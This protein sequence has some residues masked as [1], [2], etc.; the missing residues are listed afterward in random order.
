M[1]PTRLC[2]AVLCAMLPLS[3]GHAAAMDRSGQSVAALFQKGNYAEIGYSWLS[4][5]V[6]GTDTS[7]NAVPEMAKD[8]EFITGAIKVDAAPGTAL[9]FLYDQPYGADG[10]YTGNN[11]FVSATGNPF[12]TTGATLAEVKSHSYSLLVNQALNS[13][14]SVH[15]GL[16]YQTVEGDVQLRGPA[17]SVFNGYNLG[18]DSA[19]GLGW[20]LGGAFEKPDIALRAALTYRSEITTHHDTVE[21]NNFAQNANVAAIGAGVAGGTAAIPAT[22]TAL[23][24][25]LVTAQ[26]A[27]NTAAITQLTGKINQLGR[28]YALSQISPQHGSSTNVTTPQSINLDFQTGVMPG[29]LAFANVRWVDWSGFTI[30]PQLYSG[31]AQTPIVGYSKDQWSAQ[32]GLGHKF[33][34]LLSASVA[35][36]WDSGAGN[37]VT[38][39]GPTEGYTGVGV[40]VK[41][42]PTPALDV[43]LGARYLWLGDAEAQLPNGTIVGSFKDNTAVAAGIKLGYHF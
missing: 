9:A 14:L 16:S 20:V 40:G 28:L 17:Y 3:Q 25:Q 37:P 43:S 27:N 13:N 1:H 29:T 5:E 36:L 24:T 11:N 22:L 41:I 10:E 38:T 32:V 2:L 15:A 8:Y 42:T 35:A 34:D 23:N 21:T 31:V 4:P 18:M 6:A 12:G 19:G 7:G 33:N 39:L 26:A 30:S